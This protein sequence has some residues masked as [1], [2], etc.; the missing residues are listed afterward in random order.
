[1]FE[2]GLL[3]AILGMAIVFAFL[4]L[5]VAIVGAFG[6]LDRRFAAVLGADRYRNKARAVAAAIAYHRT[7][8]LRSKE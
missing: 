5:L 4:I 8:S 2:Q 7:M 1:M 3:L 6:W